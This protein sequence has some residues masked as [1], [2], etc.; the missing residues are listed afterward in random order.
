MRLVL[1]VGKQWTCNDNKQYSS[2]WSYWVNANS[3]FEDYTIT[4]NTVDKSQDEGIWLWYGGSHADK[5]NSDSVASI[6]EK[7]V[8]DNILEITLSER[9]NIE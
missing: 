4:G 1:L 8:N 2:R 5:V 6:A 3:H 9:I 7:L